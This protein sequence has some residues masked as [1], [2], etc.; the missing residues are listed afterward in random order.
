MVETTQ[1]KVGKE[2]EKMSAVSLPEECPLVWEQGGFSME[3]KNACCRAQML[4]SM[5]RRTSD[6]SSG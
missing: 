3:V 5:S 2:A 6:I 1:D 4:R